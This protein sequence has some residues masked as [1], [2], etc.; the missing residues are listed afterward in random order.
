MTQRKPNAPVATN[1][2]RQPYATVIQGT[3]RGATTAP[4]LVPALK[5][6]VANARS[7]LGNHSAT[8]LIDAGKLP[9][10]PIPRAKRA[11]PKPNTERAS[12]CPIAARLQTTTANENPFRTPSQSM[13]RPTTSNPIAYAVVKAKTTLL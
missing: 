9:D 7:F 3:T 11:A 1:A 2:H 4:I 5:I 10:S 12:A 8:A 13:I 6:P